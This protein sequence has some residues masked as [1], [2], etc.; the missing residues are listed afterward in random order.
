M[1]PH[2]L[3]NLR[4]S[5]SSTFIQS[6][7]K[8]TILFLTCFLLFAGP[9]RTTAQNQSR[10]QFQVLLYTSPDKWHNVTEP[11]ALIEFGKMAERH[12]FGLKITQVVGDFND[13]NLANYDVIV[14]LHSTTRDLSEAQLESFKK[15]I[16]G[17]GGF[18]GIHAASACGD[19]G[20]WYRKLIGRTFTDHPEEQTGVMRVMAKNHPA[21]MHLPD[22]W[23]W[24]DEW[25]AFTEPLTESMKVL[26]TVDE[27][28]YYPRPQDVMGEF[29]PVAWY[30][31]P[32]GCRLFYT[33]LGHITESYGDPV[34]LQHVF[35][36]MLWAVGERDP[37]W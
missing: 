28:T 21:T 35:G 36:G 18:V 13:E 31:Q 6:M 34:F 9:V 33:S 24:T 32:E 12:A 27:S 4:V 1:I 2:L 22:R 10:N 30:H 8:N 5:F 29:H 16:H 20:L 15:F 3:C 11:T 17:G 26:L 14:F 25:Y 19:E 23:I 7:M 37:K